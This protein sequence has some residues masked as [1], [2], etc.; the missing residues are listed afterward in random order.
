MKWRSRAGQNQYAGSVVKGQSK[1]L[2]RC[3]FGTPTIVQR[4]FE[5]AH[6]HTLD[7][8]PPDS[9]RPDHTQKTGFAQNTAE[10]SSFASK[11]QEQ[12][13]TLTERQEMSTCCCLLKAAHCVTASPDCNSLHMAEPP[14]CD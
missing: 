7:S 13:T 4:Q 10:I 9:R 6:S 5:R 11:W 12:T 1:E 8:Q 2:T 14:T 3:R